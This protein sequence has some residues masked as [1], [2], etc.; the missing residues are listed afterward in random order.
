MTAFVKNKFTTGEVAMY[1][2]KF[3]ARFKRGGRADFI[4][5]LC[6]NFTVEEYFASLEKGHL[7]LDI[8]QSK[9]Y[10]SPTVRKVLRAAGYAPTAEGQKLYIDAQVQATLAKRRAVSF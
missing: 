2:G 1:N 5:F 3:V 8:L 7:P 10:V 6:K 9:G 4:S